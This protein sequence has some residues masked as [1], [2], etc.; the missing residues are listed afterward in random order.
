MTFSKAQSLNYW[1]NDGKSAISAAMSNLQIGDVTIPGRVLI[2]PMTGVS[3]L[4]F[5][6]AAS[7]Q[8]APYVATEMVACDSFARGRPDVVR[9]AAIGAKDDENALPLMVIQLV[10]REAEWISKG[11]RLAEQAGA[12]IIDFNMGCPAKEVTGALSGSAL[13]RDEELASRLIGAAVNGTSRPVTLK[14]RLGWDDHWKNAPQIAARAE[15]LGVKAITVH[16]RTR[17]QFYKGNADWR[18]VAEVKRAVKI[19]VIV[20]GDIIDLASAQTALAQSGADAVMIGRGSY[21]RPWIASGL[22]AALRQNDAMMEPD[23]RTRLTI[24]LEHLAAS[25][26]FYGDALGLK[27]FRKHLGWY[28]ENA[29]FGTSATRREAKATLCRIESASVLEKTVSKFWLDASLSAQ[30]ASAV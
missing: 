20:N 5:R 28:V 17:Q 14:M 18:A 13:M 8:G 1:K 27:V 26:A 6:Q 22:G 29:P 15:Q 19:P 21:G 10:G 16:G 23:A 25:L 11:A 9:R 24:L 3:D 4:P 2:A 12:H 7:R 30:A